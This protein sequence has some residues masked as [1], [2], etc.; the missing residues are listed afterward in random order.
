CSA[1]LRVGSG[2]V[3][4]ETV[5]VK[6]SGLGTYEGT[7]SNDGNS[8]T[9]IWIQGAG[10]SP[11]TLQRATP[12]TEWKDPSPHTVRFMTVDNNVRLE[13]LDWGGTG[14]PMVFLAGLGNTAHVF[15][16]LAPK[17]AG[18]FHVY[19]IT[20]RGFGTSSQPAVGYSADRLAD[21]VLEIIDALKLNKPILVGHS[22]AGEELSSIGFRHADK[23]AGLVYLDAGYSY[24]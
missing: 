20:R 19:G 13:V 24:A 11:L 5:N 15:D 7:L 21:D 23:V 12:E 14:R 18:A 8:I 1:R 2:T 3:Q 6:V 4:Q 22:I 17:F 16:R 9:G 10:R